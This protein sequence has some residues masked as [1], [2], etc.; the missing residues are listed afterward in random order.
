MTVRLRNEEVTT[1]EGVQEGLQCKGRRGKSGQE[2][3]AKGYMRAYNIEA[4]QCQ[5]PTPSY[6]R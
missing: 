1:G 4:M 5:F 2:K 6:S 3:H